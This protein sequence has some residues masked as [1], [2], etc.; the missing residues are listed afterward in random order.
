M[1][2]KQHARRALAAVPQ[3]VPASTNCALPTREPESLAEFAA[4]GGASD[5]FSRRPSGERCGTESRPGGRRMGTHG[6]TSFDG[7]GVYG[8]A[9]KTPGTLVLGVGCQPTERDSC[10]VLSSLAQ[11]FHLQSDRVAFAGTIPTHRYSSNGQEEKAPG[12][13]Q[14]GWHSRSS[15]QGT[16]CRTFPIQPRNLRDGSLLVKTLTCFPFILPGSRSDPSA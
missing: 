7:M 16:H 1:A 8:G 9:W 5:R 14:D 6:R 11:W 15:E 4:A 12:Q 13:I 3:T 10:R 2:R